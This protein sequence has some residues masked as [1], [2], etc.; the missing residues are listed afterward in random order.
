M[1][2]KQPFQPIGQRIEKLTKFSESEKES[3][4]QKALQEE[5][6][7]QDQIDRE[8]K[9]ALEREEKRKR[10]TVETRKK[11]T[12]S[13]TGKLLLIYIIFLIAVPLIIDTKTAVIYALVI[14]IPGFIVIS[15]VGEIIKKLFD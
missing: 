2:D 1:D 15:L 8:R 3:D 7:R 14:A 6:N 12:D 13:I 4:R 9:D 10:E 5:R 11:Q